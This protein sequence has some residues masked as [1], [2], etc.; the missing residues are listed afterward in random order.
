[1]LGEATLN[2]CIMIMITLQTLLNTKHSVECFVEFVYSYQKSFFR[3]PTTWDFY[4]P[5]EVNIS[6]FSALK[7]SNMTLF[8]LWC[9]NIH[10]NIHSIHSSYEHRLST[11]AIYVKVDIDIATML[12]MKVHCDICTQ[13]TK[14]TLSNFN[15][16]REPLN[17]S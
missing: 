3:D 9:R 14:H 8:R 16:Y 4:K 11:Q 10:L 6:C 1:M 12:K 15:T 7:S 2:L 5:C 13:E 17:H